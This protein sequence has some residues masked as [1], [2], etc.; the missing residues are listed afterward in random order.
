[1][2]YAIKYNKQEMVEYLIKRG[3]NLE[4]KDNKGQTLVGEATKRKRTQIAELLIKSGAPAAEEEKKEKAAVKAKPKVVQEV[5]KDR[6]NER[7]IP[8]TYLLT[9]LNEQGQ[10][11]PVTDE[12]FEQFRRENP[13][14]AK[15]FEVNDDN[16][17]VAPLDELPIPDVPENAPIFD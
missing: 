11:E 4:I 8:K 12:E 1:V 5:P 2:F 7:K 14:I 17:D 15:Y 6:Q 16:E 13:D 10:Y 9:K 3:I